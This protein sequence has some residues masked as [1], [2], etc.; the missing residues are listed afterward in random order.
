MMMT[1]RVRPRVPQFASA[2]DCQYG[3]GQQRPAG[4]T[5]AVGA[6]GHSGTG[7]IQISLYNTLNVAFNA[8]QF[9]YFLKVLFLEYNFVIS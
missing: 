6:A 8:I 1:T 2:A 4:S 5:A 3:H 9:C 7:T